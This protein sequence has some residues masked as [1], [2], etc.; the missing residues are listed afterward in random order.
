MK[1]SGENTNLVVGE[2]LGRAKI[3]HPDSVIMGPEEKPRCVVCVISL[4]S[5]PLSLS[6][7]SKIRPRLRVTSRKGVAYV[8]K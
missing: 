4:V 2:R 1:C 8:S 6:T 7:S 5:K 3:N